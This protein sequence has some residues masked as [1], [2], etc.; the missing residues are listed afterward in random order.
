[1][2]QSVKL[3]LNHLDACKQREGKREEDQEHGSDLD[4]SGQDP[5]IVTGIVVQGGIFVLPNDHHSLPIVVRIQLG[6]SAKLSS[7]VV[8]LNLRTGSPDSG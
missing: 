2:N 6:V 3:Y 5:V 4:E 8:R 7:E 1:M